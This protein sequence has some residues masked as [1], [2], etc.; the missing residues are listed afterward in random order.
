MLNL[1][2]SVELILKQKL[3]EE[4]ELLIWQ[5]V[6]RPRRT[7]SLDR[8]IDRLM[9]AHVPLEKSDV[10]AIRTA[11]KWRNNITHYELDLVISEVRENYL[12]IYE[13]LDKFHLDHFQGSLSE[14]IPDEYVPIAAELAESFKR[15]IFEFRG[16]KMHRSW[17][18]KLI[19]AQRVPSLYI[20]A[21]EYPRKPWGQ[22]LVWQEKWMEGHS[23]LPY[24]RDCA[25]E[26]GEF[27]GPGCVVEECPREGGQ[28]YGCPCEWD[29]SELWALDSHEALEVTSG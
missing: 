4:H 12:L 5:D 17:P 19:A 20:A 14:H 28:L 29:P 27:H 3:F 10:N 6:D 9:A 7:V 23:P 25:T 2:H 21:V 8:A 11:V 24:C 15:E 26:L 1:V 13:F 18:K 22:E 16:R